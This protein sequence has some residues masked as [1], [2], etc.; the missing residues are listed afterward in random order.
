[1][2]GLVVL[3]KCENC[4]PFQLTKLSR[5]KIACYIGVV[6]MLM[7]ETI[8]FDNCRTAQR[9][10]FLSVRLVLVAKVEISNFARHN[11]EFSVLL[12]ISH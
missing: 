9:V 10:F 8:I 7:Q 6:T 1:M 11:I 5:F 4:Y 12:S 3:S 2:K